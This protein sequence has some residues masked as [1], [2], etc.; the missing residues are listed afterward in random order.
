MSC[1]LGISQSN[2]KQSKH[3]GIPS[4]PRYRRNSLLKGKKFLLTS[5]RSLWSS[6]SLHVCLNPGGIPKCLWSTSSELISGVN[7]AGKCGFT[8]PCKKS[9]G[10]KQKKKLLLYILIFLSQ[11]PTKNPLCDRTGNNNNNQFGLF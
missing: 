10:Y 7:S 5:C 2:G 3:L 4:F 9:K 11:P 8:P 6:F 1:L